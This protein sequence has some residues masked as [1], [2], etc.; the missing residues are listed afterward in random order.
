[1]TLKKAGGIPFY[2]KDDKLFVCLFVSND[3]TYGGTAPQIA[4]GHVD[5]YETQRDAAV[6]EVFEET[7]VD[8]EGAPR[9]AVFSGPFAGQVEDYYLSVY[10]YKLDDRVEPAVGDEGEGV[11]YPIEDALCF[12]RLDQ[13]AILEQA[14]WRAM[15]DD[16]W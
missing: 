3:G 9:H 8:V 14:K 12:I 5:E 15:L 6:R 2:I 1:M 10:L 11:W 13:Q 16:G 4:K 7:G